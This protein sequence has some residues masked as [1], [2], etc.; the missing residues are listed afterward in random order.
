MNILISHASSSD[1]VTVYP[2]RSIQHKA[3]STQKATTETVTSNQSHSR[4]RGCKRKMDRRSRYQVSK[5]TPTPSPPHSHSTVRGAPGRARI[6]NTS[7]RHR[8]RSEVSRRVLTSYV[9]RSL[10]LILLAST[11]SLPP[12]DSDRYLHERHVRNTSRRHIQ[13]FIDDEASADGEASEDDELSDAG[14][15]FLDDGDSVD[16][17]DPVD[18]EEL[19]DEEE[20]EA[21]RHTSKGAAAAFDGGFPWS[22]SK[23]PTIGQRKGSR[24]EFGVHEGFEASESEGDAFLGRDRGGNL[25]NRRHQ[26]LT[27]LKVKRAEAAFLRAI[28][29]SHGPRKAAKRRIDSSEGS[30]DSSPEVLQTVLQAGRRKKS[31]AALSPAQAYHSRVRPS[32]SGLSSFKPL[33]FAPSRRGDHFEETYPAATS[34]GRDASNTVSGKFVTTSRAHRSGNTREKRRLVAMDDAHEGDQS[35][36]PA[37]KHGG[38]AQQVRTTQDNTHEPSSDE[39][40]PTSYQQP[41]LSVPESSSS[42]EPESSEDDLE[43]L[44]LPSLDLPSGGTVDEE[45]TE[46]TDWRAS[47][48]SEEPNRQDVYG[49]MDEFDSQDKRRM[50]EDEELVSEDE[51]APPEVL[52]PNEEGYLRVHR[53]ERESTPPSAQRW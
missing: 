38:Q 7:F 6:R 17:E 23:R 35:L 40:A 39:E 31:V 46:H 10:E 18:E 25:S 30:A 27:S 24:D 29:K 51:E 37:L 53:C 47:T 48:P 22:E 50:E 45:E 42:P 33:Q 13:S 19:V 16:D 21:N 49:D 9:E 11:P 4:S 34:C 12:S 8:P 14:E 44:E 15:D 28:D 43:S 5:R 26:A 2:R 20:K 32:A 36:N 41:K 1:E 52:S 3:P